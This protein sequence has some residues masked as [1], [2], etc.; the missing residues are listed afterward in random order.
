MI[1]LVGKSAYTLAYEHKNGWNAEAFK[2]RYSEVLERYDYIVGDW[3][4]NQLRLRGFYKE[5]HPRAAKD[6]VITSLV[7]YI[8]EYCN[9]G[10]A[11]FVLAKTDAESVPPGTPDLTAAP[12]AAAVGDSEDESKQTAETAAASASHNGILMR[13]PLK[14]RA[15]GP[16]RMPGAAAVARAAAEAEKRSQQQ[17]QVPHKSGDARAVSPG[18]QNAGGGKQAGRNAAGGGAGKPNAGVSAA[19]QAEHRG[20]G[21][22]KHRG[23]RPPYAERH[24]GGADAR[25]GGQWRQG[26]DAGGSADAAAAETAGQRAEAAKN[27]SRWPGKSRRRSRFGGKSNRSEGA[28]RETEGT[29]R[30]GVE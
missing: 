6:S 4:Y 24:A 22:P 14:E 13:W 8:H 2:E 12:E 16:V 21:K 1:F 19:G 29:V 15:G 20:S 17:A 9:F 5:G 3:G 23:Q 11:Y 18:R 25:F 10:C 28:H 27:A 26:A 30:P 7:D